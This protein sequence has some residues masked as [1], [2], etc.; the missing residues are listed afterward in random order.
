MTL[1]SDELQEII[2]EQTVEENDDVSEDG[3]SDDDSDLS[4]SS[5]TDEDSTNCEINEIDELSKLVAKLELGG[6]DAKNVI[7]AVTKTGQGDDFSQGN[8]TL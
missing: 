4:S 5:D 6:I 3:Q 8:S 1:P 2:T 7:K